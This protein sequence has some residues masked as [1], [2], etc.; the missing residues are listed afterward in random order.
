[1]KPSAYTRKLRLQLALACL[2]FLITATAASQLLSG[3]SLPAKELIGPV[4]SVI[5]TDPIWVVDYHT[6]VI[7][8]RASGH[9]KP[10]AAVLSLRPGSVGPVTPRATNPENPFVEGGDIIA[11]RA[12][13]LIFDG[14]PHRLSVD[15]RGKIKK[16]QVDALRLVLPAGA[17]LKITSLHFLADPALLP[18][19]ASTPPEMPA[20]SAPLLV[21]GPLSCDGAPATSLRG[22]ES[23]SS[24]PQASKARLSIW[25]CWPLLTCQGS[26]AMMPPRLRAPPRS[27]TPAW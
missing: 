22:R 15:L 14:E 19:A 1:M 16:P 12:S 2:P 10:D 25:T 7:D 27:M 13:D 5:A 3:Y 4:Q 6:L 24:M 18:C 11:V 20:K 17:R 8:Y 21:H 23:I 26:S 9:L